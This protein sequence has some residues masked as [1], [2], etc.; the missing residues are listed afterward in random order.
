LDDGVGAGRGRTATDNR[1]IGAL[2]AIDGPFCVTL[3]YKS[4]KTEIHK[5]PPATAI[6]WVMMMDEEDEMDLEELLKL[7][8]EDAAPPMDN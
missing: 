6:A 3:V 1:G 5:Q 7:G 2:D 4:I 8:D